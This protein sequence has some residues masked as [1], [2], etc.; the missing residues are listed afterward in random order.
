L[1]LKIL[2]KVK[3]RHLNLVGFGQNLSKI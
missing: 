2:K 1:K 3:N